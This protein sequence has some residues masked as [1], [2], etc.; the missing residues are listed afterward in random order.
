MSLLNPYVLAFAVTL[1]VPPAEAQNS[2][3]S[4]D[5]DIIVQ[6]TI[7][8]GGD[9]MGFGFGSLWMMSAK[10]LIRVNPADNSFTEIRIKGAGGR[11]RGIG[12]GE[13][14]VWIPDVVTDTVFKVD[15]DNNEVIG[16]I[17][18]QMIA[19][20]GSIGVGEGAIW[21][22]SEAEGKLIRFNAKSGIQEATIAL[23][24]SGAGVV[25]DYGS[26]WVTSYEGSELYRIDPK[27]N[28]I[29]SISP[30]HPSPR[31]IASGENSIWVLNQGDGTVQRIEGA[32]GKLMATIEGGLAGGGGDITTGGGYVWVTTQQIPLA[33][34]D[35][36][37][38]SLVGKFKNYGGNGIGDAIRY[39]AGSLWI[40]G[41][42]IYRIQ[43]PS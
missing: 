23:P 20:E 28:T 6:A 27:T 32:T 29:V 2:A 12:V 24:S 18:A 43:P 21:V 11:Y 33:Q 38:N 19:S 39:G 42:S 30:L 3:G 35:P 34:I 22:F 10:S 8:K 1:M 25:V 17:P 41:S 36:R 37:T 7:A 5:V 26:V 40:S 16:R 31:F 13:E 9:F 14:A 4:G 15:P